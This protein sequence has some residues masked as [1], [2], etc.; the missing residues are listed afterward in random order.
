MNKKIVSILIVLAALFIAAPA[1][2]QLNGT[3]TLTGTVPADIAITVTPIA[4]FDSL[5]IS[6]ASAADVPVATVNEYS[7]NATYS[8]SLESANGGT[9]N[10]PSNHS[11]Q[12]HYPS[13][14]AGAAFTPTVAAIQITAGAPATGAGGVDKTLGITYTLDAGLA[15]GSYTD[16]LTFTISAD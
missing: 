14:N 15:A 10:G 13:Y 12:L 2:A 16:V 6:G 8:V 1:F 3:L 4:G 5:D 11:Y 9:L 7:S